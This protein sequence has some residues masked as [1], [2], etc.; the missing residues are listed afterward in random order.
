MR[1]EQL[2][3]SAALRAPGRPH[4]AESTYTHIADSTLRQ[5]LQSISAMI[6]DAVDVADAGTASADAE[7][8][9]V[10]VLDEKAG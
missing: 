3:R 4:H 1:T 6:H 5:I 7:P 9:G 10:V 2:Q 8:G